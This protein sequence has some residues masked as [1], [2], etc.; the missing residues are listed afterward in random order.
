MEM[1]IVVPGWLMHQ[2]LSETRSR[3]CGNG[4]QGLEDF[5]QLLEQEGGDREAIRSCLAESTH[6]YPT[7]RV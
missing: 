2:L 1:P 3:I 7:E 4:T 5:D 6:F